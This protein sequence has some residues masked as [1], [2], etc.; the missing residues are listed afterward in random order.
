MD[1]LYAAPSVAALAMA[2]AHECSGEAAFV[3]S[4]KGKGTNR[5]PAENFA[6]LQPGFC[7]FCPLPPTGRLPAFL[8]LLGLGTPR[9]RP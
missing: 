9:G 7:P 6:Y 5:C 4:P 8:L 1:I 3:S 2:F